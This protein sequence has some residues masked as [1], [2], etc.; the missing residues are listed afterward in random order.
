MP[1][2]LVGTVT[3]FVGTHRIT[4]RVTQLAA[5]PAIATPSPRC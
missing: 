5:R 4:A 1:S 3:S 2:Y